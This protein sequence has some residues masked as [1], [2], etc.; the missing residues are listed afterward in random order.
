MGWSLCLFCFLLPW[1]VSGANIAWGVLL[2]A[3][4]AHKAAGGK[5]EPAW[6]APLAAAL[7]LYLIAALWSSAGGLDPW[8]SLRSFNRDFHKLWLYLLLSAALC[9]R[10]PALAPAFLAAGFAAAAALG[11]G[12]TLWSLLAGGPWQ[13]AHAL[14][15]PVLFGEQMALGLL[16]ACCVLLRPP[17]GFKAYRRPLA[18]FALLLA[19]ALL[20]SMTRAALLAFLVGAAVAVYFLPKSRRLLLLLIPALALGAWAALSM[21]RL[22]AEPL[23]RELAA[24]RQEGGKLPAHGPL[25]RLSL[26]DAALRIGGERPWTG[27]GPRNFRPAF[28]RLRPDAVWD[29][30]DA[31]NVFLHQFAE[32][33]LP[34]LAALLLLGGVFALRSFQRAALEPTAWTLWA[35]GASA[36]FF[37]MNLTETAF[38][39]ELVWML[40][41][42]IWLWAESATRRSA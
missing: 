25:M 19:A 33:G 8:R 36:A 10:R 27:V 31:H 28:R 32:R 21:G 35:A 34:G 3:L 22:R 39:T 24:W 26:W 29:W 23:E 12:Q 40:M 20:L 38:E 18:A 2:A 5:V 14:V 13:R 9:V 16:G 11:V 15:H 7:A 30:G 4:L 1:T 41:L 42:W 37:V 17:E 6:R